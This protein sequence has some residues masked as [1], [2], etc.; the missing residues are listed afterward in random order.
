MLYDLAIFHAWNT[1]TENK[2]LPTCEFSPQNLLHRFGR[3]FL[4]TFTTYFRHKTL[5]DKRQQQKQWKAGNLALFSVFFSPSVAIRFNKSFCFH[6][7]F[8][9]VWVRL[10]LFLRAI[11]CFLQRYFA[12]HTLTQLTRLKFITLPKSHFLLSNFLHASFSLLM[13]MYNDYRCN[14]GQQIMCFFCRQVKNVIV[15]IT[16]WAHRKI[17][18]SA[19]MASWSAKA[20][21][22]NI[23]PICFS[24]LPR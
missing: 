1:L 15:L 22:G 2:S 7:S 19:K 9:F 21:R 16:L 5:N 11:C 18:R 14:D 24:A 13:V 20:L 17:S 6:H 8:H 4:R 3:G 23:F 12:A 10:K